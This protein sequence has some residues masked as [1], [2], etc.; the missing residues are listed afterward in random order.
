MVILEEKAMVLF[1]DS[2]GLGHWHLE[3]IKKDDRDAVLPTMV[4]GPQEMWEGR[5]EG[6][7]IGKCKAFQAN[8]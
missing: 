6:M 4:C 3:K 1:R 2:R 5:W 8:L 7:H